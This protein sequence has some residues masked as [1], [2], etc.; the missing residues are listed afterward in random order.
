VN[1]QY[2]E[3]ERGDM[4]RINGTEERIGWDGKSHTWAW[5][6]HEHQERWKKDIETQLLKCYNR[7]RRPDRQEFWKWCLDN[8]GD[9]LIAKPEELAKVVQKV[10]NDYAE[11]LSANNKK[12]RN[13]VRYIFGYKHSK[14][15]YLANWLNVKTCPYCNMHYTIYVDGHTRKAKMAKFQFDHFY[16]KAEYP[17]L[18]MSLYNL[19]P[20][21][22][23]CNQGKSKG[24]LD[25]DF[26]PYHAAIKDAFYFRVAKPLPLWKGSDS[27][28]S[29]I[30][31]VAKDE[32]KL[33]KF[34]DMFHVDKLYQHHKDVVR[35]TF[36]RVY[37]ERYYSCKENFKFLKDRELARRIQ[38]GGYPEEADIDKRPLTKL[39]IDMRK[40]AEG[41]DWDDVFYEDEKD[42]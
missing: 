27:E 7:A 19:I 32:E 13:E 28:V 35:E 36:T 29:D 21:C 30:E 9:W 31:M 18:S 5:I 4:L 23:S 22:A 25:L 38:E 33:K 15:L 3:S 42:V 1:A 37:A 12:I 10:K 17:M 6:E 40:Q 11:L 39:Q 26:N 24:E 2:E 20:S 41:I 16:D 8:A 34:N 14:L